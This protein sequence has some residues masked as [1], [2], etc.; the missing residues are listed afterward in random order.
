MKKATSNFLPLAAW[1]GIIGPA[2]FVAVFLVEGAIRPGYNPLAEFVSALSLGPRGWIQI[3]NFII[4]GLLLFAFSRAVAAEFPS[5]K[6]SRWGLILL[7]VTAVCYFISGPSVMDPATGTANEL[8]GATFHGL[9]HGIMGGIVFLLMP[10]VMF[11]YLRRFLSDPKWK[12]MVVWTW[13]L[14]IICA[15]DDIFFTAVSKSPDLTAQFSSWMGLI[16]RSVIIPFMIWVFVFAVGL[17]R[18][19]SLKE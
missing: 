7:T 18:H 9:L 16:Q 1:A 14:G 4:F 6:A 2:L 10:I 13:V 3:T 15:V 19:N 8:V 5:G 12:F 17:Y 11:V